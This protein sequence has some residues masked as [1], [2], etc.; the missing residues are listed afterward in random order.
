MTILIMSFDEG[1]LAQAYVNAICEPCDRGD[2]SVLVDHDTDA[3]WELPTAQR[4]ALTSAA[5]QVLGTDKIMGDLIAAIEPLL[6]K[7]P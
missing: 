5:R 2:C 1:D 4:A 7:K 3:Y 6:V